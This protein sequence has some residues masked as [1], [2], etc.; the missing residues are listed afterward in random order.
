ML[1]LRDISCSYAFSLDKKTMTTLLRLINTK[2]ERIDI[3]RYLEQPRDAAEE[4][5]RPASPGALYTCVAECIACW[6]PLQL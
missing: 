2:S 4:Q 5:L 3:K 1:R 6:H